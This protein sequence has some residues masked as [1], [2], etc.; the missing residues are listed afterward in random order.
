MCKLSVS[1]M[2][3]FIALLGQVALACL[4]VIGAIDE[5]RQEGLAVREAAITGAVMRFR[6][7]I[8]TALLAMLGLLPMA[9][10]SGMGSETQRPFALVLI[11][12]MMTTCATALFVLPVVYTFLASKKLDDGGKAAEAEEA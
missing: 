12:G 10:S 1:A 2:I 5:K 11:G 7:V 3:G 4:L 8:M 9:V 6:A